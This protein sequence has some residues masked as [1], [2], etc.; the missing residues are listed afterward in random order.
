MDIVWQ[1]EG[2]E[3]SLWIKENVMKIEN[4]CA[5]IMGDFIHLASVILSKM[6]RKYLYANKNNHVSLR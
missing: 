3:A 4:E 1:E 6:A 2:R 5:I